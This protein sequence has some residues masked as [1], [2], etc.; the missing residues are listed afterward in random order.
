[1]NMS[2]II[3]EGNYGAIDADDYL[4]NGYYIIKFSS[5]PYT[6]QA[7]MSIDGQVIYSGE[8]VCEVS[9]YFPININPHYYVLIYVQNINSYNYVKKNLNNKCFSLRKRIDGNVN[10]ICYD[11]KNSIPPCLPSISNND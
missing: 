6:L 10:L 2:S 4:C 1:M 8:M 7:D 5:S 11:S 9:Y 3:M